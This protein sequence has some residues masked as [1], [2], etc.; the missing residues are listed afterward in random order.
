MSVTSDVIERIDSDESAVHVRDLVQND[1]M[2][3]IREMAEE[4]GVCCGCCQAT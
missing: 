3:I 2:R 4:L 1:K